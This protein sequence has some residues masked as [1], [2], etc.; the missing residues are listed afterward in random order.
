MNNLNAELTIMRESMVFS[1]LEPIKHN[2]NH[3]NANCSFFELG[4]QYSRGEQQILEEEKLSLWLTGKIKDGNWL[5]K[6]QDV[7]F[8]YLKSV[9][10][11]ILAL[12]GV[13]G[14]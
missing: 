6:G 7:D 13:K 8:Y 9:V 11:Q 4:K 12:C 1:G 2:I 3:R 5:E 10:E 14:F